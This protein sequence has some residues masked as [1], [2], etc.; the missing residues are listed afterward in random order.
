M[1]TVLFRHSPLGFSFVGTGKK[2]SSAFV[3]E[4]YKNE[5]NLLPFTGMWMK[6][7]QPSTTE[8]INNGNRLKMCFQTYI[9]NTYHLS[10]KLF[11]FSRNVLV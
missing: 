10:V 8:N 5:D 7:M 3:L 4:A 2:M 9:A 6:V 11:V 1:D